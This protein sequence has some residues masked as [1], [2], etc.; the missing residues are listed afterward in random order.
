LEDGKSVRLA[1]R[2]PKVL[3]ELR[4]D[5]E[6]IEAGLNGRTTVYDD[7]STPDYC[8]NGRKHLGPILHMHKPICYIIIGLGCND[9]KLRFGLTASIIVNNIIALIRDVQKNDNIGDPQVLVL[10]PAVPVK[11]PKSEDWN[12]GFTE[13]DKIIKLLRTRVQE[14]NAVLVDITAPV[15]DDGVHFTDQAHTMIAEKINKYLDDVV[16]VDV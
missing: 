9:L 5:L 4:P 14:V 12:F 2:W 8:V 15:G 1:G 10:P 16:P 6:I 11:T 7:P 13:G 3:Q